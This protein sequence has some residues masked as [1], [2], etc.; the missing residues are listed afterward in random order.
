LPFRANGLLPS[1][2]TKSRFYHCGLLRFITPLELFRIMG[3]PRYIKIGSLTVVEAYQ[4]A[5]NTM[6]APMI[7]LALAACS[8]ATGHLQKG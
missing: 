7:G 8:V 3:Y 4:M 1:V 2:T 5:G 6:A